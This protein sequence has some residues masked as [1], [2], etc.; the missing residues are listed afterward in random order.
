MAN[1]G[2]RLTE[3]RKNI[4]LDIRSAAEATK[5]RRDFLAA[6]EEN[7]PEKIDLADVYK[8][9]FMRIYASYLK[10]DNV[11]RIVAEFRTALSIANTSGKGSHRGS[12]LTGTPAGMTGENSPDAKP[13]RGR[14]GLFIGEPTRGRF[15]SILSSGKGL[16][17]VVAVAIVI[18]VAIAVILLSSSDET[19]SA[20]ATTTE[21]ATD[22][23]QVYEF[24]IRSKI[25]QKI[26]ITDRYGDSDDVRSVVIDATVPANR[27]QILRGRGTLEIRDEV[28]GNLEIRFP[29]VNALRSATAEK[30]VG[31]EASEKSATLSSS[32]NYWVAD[33]LAA[34]AA[35]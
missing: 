27:P 7:K 20:S 19:S 35:N 31:F 16:W 34:S 25:P 24:E 13:M 15:S 33:P 11:D 9:G 4:G 2:E 32:S 10:L 29:S 28:G 5:I 8:I 23:V 1:I 14:G 22:S 17:A 3:A 30:I 18:V 26:K 21:N 6:L 12:P